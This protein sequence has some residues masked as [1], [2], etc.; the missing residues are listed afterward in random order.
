M[1]NFLD[2][3]DW[4]GLVAVL[5]LGLCALILAVL[6]L[7]LPIMLLKTNS[8]LNALIA[9][10]EKTNQLLKQRSKKATAPR[11]TAPPK[12][13]GPQVAEKKEPVVTLSDI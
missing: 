4:P 1:A 7:L 12:K 10:T 5:A 13:R 2:G 6:W 3:L 11:S 8:K 9:A